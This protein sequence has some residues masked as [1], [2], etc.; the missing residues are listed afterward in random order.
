MTDKK[1]HI[2]NKAM[3]LFAAKGFEGTSIRDLAAAADVN[4]AMV[5]Y[6][7]GSKE[8]L[9]ES[10]VETK[11]S[12]TRGILD[13]IIKNQDLTSIEKVNLIIETYVTNLFNGRPFHLLIHQELML[14]NRETLQ[15]AILNLLFPNSLMIRDLIV[16]GIKSGEFKKVDPEM[17]F[18]TLIGTIHQVVQSKRYCNKF[19]NREEGYS[20]Y[21][22]PIFKKRVID[23]LK[24]LMANHLVK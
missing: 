22:D 3:E 12:N 1:T 6:Y 19:I 21:E 18:A 16:S 8:K 4:V 23:H 9:F 24:L 5:N 17:T 11:A 14:G 2:I 20:P 15:E 13:G 10:L 7:F